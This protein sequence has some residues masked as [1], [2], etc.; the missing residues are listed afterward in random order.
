MSEFLFGDPICLT[1]ILYVNFHFPSDLIRAIIQ[2]LIFAGKNVEI[3]IVDEL[4]VF[5]VI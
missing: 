2:N 1:N 3:V 4:F 5:N